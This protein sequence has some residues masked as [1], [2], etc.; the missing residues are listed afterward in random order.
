MRM[1]KRAGFTLIELMITIGIILILITIAVPVFNKVRRSAW[2]TSTRA[3]I[4]SLD[5]A[6][7]RYY[8][9]YNAYPG[10][11]PRNRLHSSKALVASGI[12]DFN[13]GNVAIND[14]SGAENLVL[15]LLGGIRPVTGSA[16]FEFDKALIGRG[17]R[18]LNP[19]NPKG[20]KEAYID[21]LT[22]SEGD[23]K[24]GAGDANDSVI[25]EIL[26][27]FPNS[28]PILYARA[29]PG[30]TGVVSLDGDDAANAIGNTQYDIRE[31][32][33]YTKGI[34]GSSIG[35]GKSI[36][37]DAYKNVP[38]SGSELPHGLQG[39]DSNKTFDKGAG[40]NYTYP[41]DAFPYFMNRAIPPTDSTT[42]IK[43]N[44][45]G[46]PK[47]KDKY[48]LISAGLDRVYGTDDDL[49]NAGSVLE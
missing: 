44:Q 14:V 33:G 13:N 38:I 32:H 41:Y 10:P 4:S 7:Q 27:R 47:N 1:K 20:A 18:G 29:A 19:L 30:A 26:D 9:D 5:G 11:L 43:K 16:N 37:R 34:S 36:R 48:I 23:Y 46:T 17:P 2:E 28:M 8:Q 3:Q 40:A 42:P 21:G 39:V 6:I 35:E 12:L 49:T 22:L 45:T 31:I 25:P 24:D 15:G